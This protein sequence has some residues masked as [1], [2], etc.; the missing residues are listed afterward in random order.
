MVPGG[1]MFRRKCNISIAVIFFFYLYKT[2]QNLAK[3]IQLNTNNYFFLVEKYKNNDKV[4]IY[5][6][7]NFV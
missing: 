6:I 2:V 3:T 7:V 5:T 1:K 4:Q